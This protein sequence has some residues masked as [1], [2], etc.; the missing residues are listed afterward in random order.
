MRVRRARRRYILRLTLLTDICYRLLSLDDSI[1]VSLLQ[2]Y[3]V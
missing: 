3:Q 1:L 2:P